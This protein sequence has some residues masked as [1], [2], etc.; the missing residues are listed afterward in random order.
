MLIDSHFCNGRTGTARS[1]RHGCGCP[2]KVKNSTEPTRKPDVRLILQH[3]N[4]QSYADILLRPAIFSPRPPPTTPGR[5]HSS[6][7]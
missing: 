1:E 5:H 6:S 4:R 2:V 7:G 3:E